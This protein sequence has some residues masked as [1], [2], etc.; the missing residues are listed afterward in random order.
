M[1]IV[2]R[3]VVMFAFLWAVTRAVGTGLATA[4]FLG[5]N[6]PYTIDSDVAISSESASARP[7]AAP[8]GMPMASSSGRSSLATTGS[9]R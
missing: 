5:T 3:A 8:A 7:L 2:I 4:M 9:A 6:S 1:E